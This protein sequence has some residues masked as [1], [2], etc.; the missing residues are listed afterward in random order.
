MSWYESR[1]FCMQHGGDLVS[2]HSKAENAMITGLVRFQIF[3]LNSIIA[4]FETSFL[5]TLAGP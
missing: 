3:F 5:F 1:Q 4:L 2:I